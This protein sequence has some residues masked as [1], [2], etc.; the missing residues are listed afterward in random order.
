MSGWLAASLVVV[1]STEKLLSAT[2]IAPSSSTPLTTRK[3]NPATSTQPTPRAARRPIH[4]PSRSATQRKIPLIPRAA[5]TSAT[6]INAP[7]TGSSNWTRTPSAGTPISSRI[8][9]CQRRPRT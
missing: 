2:P 9:S 6:K 5:A 7:T 3:V 1:S 4:R 8:C